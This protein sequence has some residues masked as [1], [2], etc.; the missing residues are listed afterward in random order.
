MRRV[1]LVLT[2]LLATPAVASADELHLDPTDAD[3]QVQVQGTATGKR[4]VFPGGHIELTNARAKQVAAQLDPPPAPPPDSDGDGF[5]ES[6]DLCPNDAGVAPDGCPPVVPPP[7]DSDGDGVLGADDSCPNV[8][9]PASNNGCPVTQPAPAG[10]PIKQRVCVNTH[11]NYSGGP[12]QNLTATKQKLDYLGSDCIRDTMTPDQVSTQANR[13]DA[14]DADVIAMCGGHGSTWWWEGTEA[15]CVSQA[16]QQVNRLV[17]VEGMNEPYGCSSSSSGW[18]ANQTRLINHMTRLR[19]AAAANGLDA[20]SIGQCWQSGS[21]NWYTGPT[22]AGLVNNAHSYSAP[23]TYPTLT[24]LD[25][26]IRNTTFSNSGRFV[27]TEMGFYNPVANGEALGARA[28]LAAVLNHLYRGAERLALYELQDWSPTGE[29]FGFWSNGGV[30][31]QAATALHNLMGLLGEARTVAPSGYSVSDP[32]GRALTLEAQ[33]GTAR[34][35]ALWNR[36][37]T[38]TRNVTLTLGR[39]QPVTVFRPVTGTTGETRA[40]GV[41]HVVSLGDDPVV[42]KVG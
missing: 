42:V 38:A 5:P 19:D 3:V 13:F 40:S 21:A 17:A 11:M 2:V 7:P 6:S 9:G 28:Q 12:Y 33:T 8:A 39:A 35:V 23:G 26:W 31:R 15:A 36:Q 24:Q 29:D 32:A 14:L 41:S 10:L 37:S 27:S 16:K 25:N 22:I 20:Y 1:A 18:T 34:Y 30:Q 4:L